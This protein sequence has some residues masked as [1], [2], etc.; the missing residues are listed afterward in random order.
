MI[1]Q[2]FLQHNLDQILL[3]RLWKWHKVFNY[4]F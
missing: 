3:Q 1:Q 2:M 4:N